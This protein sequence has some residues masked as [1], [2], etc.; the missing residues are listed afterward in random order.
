MEKVNNITDL[1]ILISR[2]MAILFILKHPKEAM[3]ILQ[4][5]QEI[6]KEQL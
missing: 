5:A 1:V 3:K 2:V 4:Q 6:D